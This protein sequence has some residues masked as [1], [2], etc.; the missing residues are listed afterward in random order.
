M[1]KSDELGQPADVF[2]SVSP[3]E[4]CHQVVEGKAAV[5]GAALLQEIHDAFRGRS[6]VSEDYP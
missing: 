2:L 4:V 1:L 3:E 5:S 6:A